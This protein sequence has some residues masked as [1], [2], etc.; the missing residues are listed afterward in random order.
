MF[1]ISS[2]EAGLRNTEYGK[3]PLLRYL[4]GEPG[5]LGAFLAKLGPML[6]KY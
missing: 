5:V 4:R 6:G 2:F 1:T 3:F